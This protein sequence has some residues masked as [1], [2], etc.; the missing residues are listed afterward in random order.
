MLRRASTSRIRIR[1][2]D[3]VRRPD[4]ERT[5][6]DREAFQE[7]ITALFRS[8]TKWTTELDDPDRTTEIVSRAFYTACAGRPGP[9]GDRAAEGHA[10]G[11]VAPLRT[12]RPMS[13]WKRRPATSRCR[14]WRRCSRV[15][16]VRC[17]SS[18]ARAGLRKPQRMHRLA[19]A[20]ACRWPTATGAQHFSIRCRP[21]FAG[22]LGLGPNPSLVARVKDSDLIVLVGG[23]MVKFRHRTIRC[24]SFPPAVADRSHS[25]GA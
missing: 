20:G 13:P 17:S 23:R 14:S 4:I 7:M 10:Q 6:R 24:S 22:D 21:F 3:H 9:V 15:R 12:R 1:P 2:G 16:S 11:G 19:E 25:S 8:M 5:F 18:A